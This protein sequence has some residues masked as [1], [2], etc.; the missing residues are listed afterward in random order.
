M[1][2]ILALLLIVAMALSLCACGSKDVSG[3]V[4]PAAEKP[5][6]E[7]PAAEEPTAEEPAAE[8]P[9][10]E[11]PAAE[12]EEVQLGS[13]NGGRYENAFLGVGCE[14]SKS[15]TIADE[16]QLADMV[17]LT[18]EAVG[19]DY[20]EAMLKADMFYDLYAE[21]ADDMAS[22][23]III[24][25][26]GPT[27]RFISVEDIVDASIEDSKAQL[28]AAGFSEITMEKNSLS[29]A[30]SECQGLKI[31]AVV[32]G[33]QVYEQQVYIKKGEHMGVITVATYRDD[34]TADFCDLFFALS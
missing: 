6:A 34:R 13:L 24:Q 15:W 3:T 4:T 31:S 1:K 17:G 28:E 10:A 12:E 2:K 27:A 14:L 23:N 5:A 29:F 16:Q 19:G 20:A 11:E 26:I 32:Q 9:A 8:E 21:S 22:I 25:N 18:A 7:E 30:G 33:V